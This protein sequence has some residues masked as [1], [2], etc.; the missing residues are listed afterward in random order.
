M[1]T[2]LED[3]LQ[4]DRIAAVVLA[5]VMVGQ[6]AASKSSEKLALEI[7][8]HYCGA[9]YAGRFAAV[10]GKWVPLHESGDRPVVPV[11]ILAEVSDRRETLT[12][13]NW[14][15][16]PLK[17][18]GDQGC[19][20]VRFE[21]P[22]TDPAVSRRVESWAAAITVGNRVA[23]RH[24]ELTNRAQHL[25]ALLGM[26]HEWALTHD[27]ET[28]LRAITGAA[29]T[30]LGADRATLFL[31]DKATETLVGRPALGVEQEL[32]V[33][34]NKGLVGQVF[35]TGKSARANRS[36]DSAIDRRVDRQL[37]YE[38]KTLLCVPLQDHQGKTIGAF[39]AI[40]KLS[41]S[42]TDDDEAALTELA[43]HAA[44]ALENTRQ[45]EQLAQANRGLAEEAA[46][47]VR[48]IGDSP[49]ISSL[50]AT[51]RRVAGTELSVLI[52]GEHGTGKEVV[53]R[54]IH[55]LSPRRNAPFV[56]VNC[57][58]IAESLL[59][60]E[61]FGHEK[62]AFTDAGESRPGKFELASGGTLLLD[63]I[64]DM[65]LPGQ[66]KLL[67][68][69]EEKTVVRVGGTRPLPADVRILAATNQDLEELV[70]A[71]RFREDLYFRLHVVTLELPPLRA[72]GDD[73][74]LLVEHFLESFATQAG[75]KPPRIAPEAM[76]HLLHHSWP[77]NV[78]ELRNL[79]ERLA[80][81]SSGDTVEPDE[82][83]LTTSMMGHRGPAGINQNLPLAE[84]TEKFQI[85]YIEGAISAAKG[86]MS[87]AAQ[88][89]GLH[90]SNFYRKIRQLGMETGS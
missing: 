55:F 25:E 16:V 27:S 56:A 22:V 43:K 53:A 68:V 32:R 19:L 39:E 72:R 74:A 36:D 64:G 41:G 6:A 35:R 44:V 29:A 28:L 67:R 60:S 24:A 71:S 1:D 57:A 62:G 31:W 42:F 18:D 13:Q 30:M 69:L 2:Q 20:L 9:T 81:L 52:R 73:I 17:D 47:G 5:K 40:N 76:A 15:G 66:A 82:L 89:L 11:T 48:L 61:L 51:I 45:R 23:S 26:I 4:A 63:E 33:P 12:L 46:A 8:R 37:G 78:R 21:K 50:R 88:R 49:A 65:S 75:R 85:G 70:R 7:G 87:L 3:R 59:E 84:A 83:G 14:I 10:D 58:A 90:R 79:M 77:G 54:L 38:T 86:N 80:Y 34:D